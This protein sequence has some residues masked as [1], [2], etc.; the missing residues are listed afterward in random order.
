MLTI[1]IELIANRYHANPWNRAHVEGTVEWPPSPWRLLRA[2]C[3]GGF[4]SG[5]TQAEIIPV[6][7]K[8][9]QSLPSFH[10]PIGTYL[11]TRSPRK[12]VSHTTDL[13]KMGKDVCDAYLNF[14]ASDR[15]IWVQWSVV[16]AESEQLFLARCIAYCRYLGRREADAIWTIADSLN[17]PTANAIA[18]D[19]GTTK[20]ACSD[21]NCEALL[22]SPY[23]MQA[24]EKRAVFPGL[25]WCN[26][27]VEEMPTMGLRA[28]EFV[29]YR[30]DIAISAQGKPLARSASYWADKLHQALA[31]LGT[32]N[33][34][35][36]DSS[37]APLGS[38]T[39]TFVLPKLQDSEQGDELVGFELHSPAGFSEEE[40]EHLSKL[41]KLYARKNHLVIRVVGLA[42]DRG[43]TAQVWKSQT[44]FFL[45]RWPLTRN[46]KPRLIR[47]TNYQKDGP[48]HQALKSLCYL[49]QFQLSPK[50]CQ[51]E[52]RDEGLAMI[53]DSQIIAVSTAQRWPQSWR[54]R[55]DRQNGKRVGDSG[56]RLRLS[57]PK[58][59]VG[60]IAIGYSAHFGLGMLRGC[61]G[62]RAGVSRLKAVALVE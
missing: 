5:A 51:F 38:H 56:Y 35:G 62:V 28:P 50:D 18:K 7:E 39:H 55:Y 13:F 15:T 29:Y 10:L 60:P 40:I 2:I 46:G 23:Q 52:E 20:V 48:E 33:F 45:T 61:V 11:Q 8:L 16:L 54:W 41:R 30:A 9:A 43:E 25:K 44:P 19:S 37:G 53:K 12:D 1:K 4:A 3:A 6:V 36:C 42:S 22:K 49:P 17:M 32:P 14:D 47:G 34:T 59:V 31:R 58:P 21:G 27:H 26:Y 24:I 57:F